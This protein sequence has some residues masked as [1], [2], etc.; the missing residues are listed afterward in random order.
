MEKFLTE[1]ETARR[2]L[3]DTE[4]GRL[5]AAILVLAHSLEKTAPKLYKHGGYPPT[6]NSYL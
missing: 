1:Y 3:P 5:A 2:N 6:K 4:A